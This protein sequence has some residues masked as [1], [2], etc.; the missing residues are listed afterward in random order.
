MSKD[1]SN[2]GNSSQ[3]GYVV[4]LSLLFVGMFLVKTS[5]IKISIYYLSHITGYVFLVISIIGILIEV[6]E[7]AKKITNSKKILGTD[8]ISAAIAIGAILL[9]TWKILENFGIIQDWVK[10][11][12]SLLCFLPVYGLLR[13]FIIAF[14]SLF[15][16]G[17]RF[18]G[19]NLL[20]QLMGLLLAFA[21]LIVDILK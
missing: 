18:N 15:N 4:A 2:D 17:S 14:Q 1:K 6:S 7:S 3:E 8:D 12:I 5:Y 21:T 9:I 10:Y 13:G 16:Q 19:F 11:L 20:I